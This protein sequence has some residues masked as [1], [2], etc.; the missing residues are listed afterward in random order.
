MAGRSLN[1]FLLHLASHPDELA[2]RPLEELAADF[3]LGEEAVAL[4]AGGS[5]REIKVEVTLELQV[6]SAATPLSWIH[7]WIHSHPKKT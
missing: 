3:G 7:V 4:L 5:L 6:D 2:A 1:D